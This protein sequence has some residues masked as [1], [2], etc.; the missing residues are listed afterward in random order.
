MI[1]LS[2]SAA[3]VSLSHAAAVELTTSQSQS[4]PS[5]ILEVVGADPERGAARAVVVVARSE[6]LRFTE[7][8]AARG[9]A[10]E[11]VGVVDSGLAAEAGLPEGTQVLEFTGLFQ[12]PLAELRAAHER[13]LPAVLG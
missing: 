5:G 10:A 13:T 3:L 8:C 2:A 1:A 6:E 11:R 12:V 4:L 7:M 9:L